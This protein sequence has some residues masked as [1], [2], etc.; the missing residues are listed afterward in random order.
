MISR[1]HTTPPIHQRIRI[2]PPFLKPHSTTRRQPLK[3]ITCRPSCILPLPPQRLRQHIHNYRHQH[4]HSKQLPLIPYNHLR[5]RCA[6]PTRSIHPFARLVYTHPTPYG[7]ESWRNKHV[8]P[9]QDCEECA[10][11]GPCVGCVTFSFDVADRDRDVR[12]C[13]RNGEGD[14]EVALDRPCGR[15]AEAEF[16]LALFGLVLRA[17]SKTR[18]QQTSYRKQYCAVFTAVWRRPVGSVI[19]FSEDCQADAEES[20]EG[21]EKAE[22]CGERVAPIRPN[23]CYRERHDRECDHHLIYC[24][25]EMVACE[26]AFA[27]AGK[28]KEKCANEDGLRIR[29]AKYEGPSSGS[30]DASLHRTWVVGILNWCVFKPGE[31]A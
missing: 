11:F 8:E 4:T 14:E 17:R 3:R 2:R 24:H 16:G 21:K 13:E 31:R 25:C 18:F 6:N 27:L 23:Q 20:P 7:R 28:T 12:E 9:V 26:L 10:S 29:H 1:L 5:I 22:G 19:G 30:E 15:F